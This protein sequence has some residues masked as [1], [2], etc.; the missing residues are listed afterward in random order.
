VRYVR[1]ALSGVSG[2]AT[3]LVDSLALATSLTGAEEPAAGTGFWY[4][5]RPDCPVGSWQSEI[6]AEPA[7]DAALP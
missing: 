3:D 7:R 1:G 2:Y 6:G 5:V 4:L